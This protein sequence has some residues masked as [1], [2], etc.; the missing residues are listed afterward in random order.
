MKFDLVLP[1]GIRADMARYQGLLA[2]ALKHDEAMNMGDLM[3][4]LS[5]GEFAL[6][7]VDLHGAKGVIVVEINQGAVNTLWVRYVSGRI[8]GPPRVWIGRV[9]A[10]QIYFEG[11]ARQMGCTEIRVCGRDWSRILPDWEKDGPRHEL[12]LAL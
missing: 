2:P 3:R 4:A 7:D 11:I 5:S 1:D 12:R 8:S 6:Y 9:K 10:L